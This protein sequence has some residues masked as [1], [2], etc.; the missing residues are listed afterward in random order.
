MFVGMEA[1]RR[2]WIHVNR[3][4]PRARTGAAAGNDDASGTECGHSNSTS[5]DRVVD[6]IGNLLELCWFSTVAVILVQDSQA[7]IHLGNLGIDGP[8]EYPISASDHR[9][10][11]FE[12]IPGKSDAGAYV[13]V[14]GIQW[15]ELRVNLVTYS[16]VQR[17]IGGDF[18]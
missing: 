12:W 3:N 13:A 1:S 7:Q 14:I 4:E 10:V 5:S 6:L 15:L 9:L 16:I 8:I 17:E 11:V 2:E 18:P